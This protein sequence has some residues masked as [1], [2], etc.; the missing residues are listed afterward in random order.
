MKAIWKTTL[1]LFLGSLLAFSTVGCGK[2]TES[3]SDAETTDTEVQEVTESDPEA[4]DYTLDYDSESVPDDLAKTIALY[5]YAIDTQ[6]YDLYLE[7]INSLYQ[8]NME[9]WLQENYGYGMETG[10]EQYH[11]TLVDYAGTEEYTIT[12]MSFA[13]AEEALADDFDEGT[14]FTGEYLDTYSEVFGEDFTT[15]LEE[16]STGIYDVAVTMTGV[17]GDG[18][19]ITILSGLEL[20]VAETD[21]SFGILG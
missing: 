17:D 6:N 20:L 16:E 19:D 12:G 18:N 9:T 13:M 4:M 14:D 3:S 2:S 21:G 8:T 10:F 5:F 7:Q 11:Q 1:A 15:Q